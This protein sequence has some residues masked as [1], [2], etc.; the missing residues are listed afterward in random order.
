MAITKNDAVAS[1]GVGKTEALSTGR[2]ETITPSSDHLP[3]ET[4]L[5]DRL[6]LRSPVGVGDQQLGRPIYG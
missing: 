5:K 6:D 1:R 3:T 4:F 2:A